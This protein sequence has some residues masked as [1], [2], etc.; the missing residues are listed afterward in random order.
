MKTPASKII[1]VLTFV[2]CHSTFVIPARAQTAF[3]LTAIPPRLEITVEPGRTVTQEIKV[4]NESKNP[5]IIDITVRDFV[6]ADDG[7]TPIQIDT[8]PDENRWAASSWIQLSTRQVTLKPLETRSLMMT[9]IAPANATPGGHYAM[10]LHT[11]GEQVSLTDTGAAVI[12]NVGTLVYITVPGDIRQDARV[13]SFSAPD[14]SEFGPINFKSIITNLSDIHIK[15]Q[16]FIKVTNW[17]GGNTVNL[18]LEDTNIFP[19][20]SREFIN[21]LDKKFLF[22]RYKAQLS[23]GYGTAGGAL[24]A[25]IYFWVIP[26]RLIILILI[27]IVLFAA[28]IHLIRKTQTSANPEAQRQIGQLE[29]EIEDLKKKYSDKK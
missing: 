24:L 9:V 20:T 28:L 26:W 8:T 14:F 6:V 18:P 3:G 15:P 16:G 29:K 10:I 12:A 17:L 27:F 25:T 4:R 22:G 23:A 13:D 19:Y 11:P 1:F 7:G 5:K 21:K 2:I